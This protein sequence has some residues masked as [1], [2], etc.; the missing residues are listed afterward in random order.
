MSVTYKT[1]VVVPGR[2]ADGDRRV[3][4][5]AEGDGTLRFASYFVNGELR[6]CGTELIMLPTEVR[7]ECEA[8][9]ASTPESSPLLW[10]RR[11]SGFAS[12]LA[13]PASP[14]RQAMKSGVGK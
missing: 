8:R 12:H 5:I 13:N 9:L 11:P 14:L 3:E 2:R 7:E 4:L 1:N 10:R 6:G